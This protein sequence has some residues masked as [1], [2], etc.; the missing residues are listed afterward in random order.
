MFTPF[1][2]SSFLCF[3]LFGF[4][5]FRCNNLRVPHFRTS[6]FQGFLILPSIFVESMMVLIRCA[7]VMVVASAK[8][9]RIVFCS[10]S[11]VFTE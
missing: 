4:P 1:W 2:V 8:F 10:S 3:L 7:I 5:T 11:S 6:N 9:E